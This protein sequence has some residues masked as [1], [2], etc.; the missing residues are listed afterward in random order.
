MKFELALKHVKSGKKIRRESYKTTSHLEIYKEELVRVNKNGAV[1]PCR[2]SS[3]DL[4]AEDW[5]SV[6]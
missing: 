2:I 6:K 1:K 5:K 3:S 4:L